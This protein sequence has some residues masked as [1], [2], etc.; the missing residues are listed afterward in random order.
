M[1][2]TGKVLIFAGICAAVGYGV[3]RGIG[4]LNKIRFKKQFDALQSYIDTHYPGAD[5][6]NI[7]PF[8]DGWK[9]TVLYDEQNIIVNILPD[10][11]GSF[12]FSPTEV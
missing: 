6:G 12:I 9:C 2:K 7:V 1:K 3:W 10:D 4:P 8:K 11:S 5:I